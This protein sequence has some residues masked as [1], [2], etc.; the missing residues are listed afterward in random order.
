M[1]LAA[2][3]SPRWSPLAFVAAN[4]LA[5]V[6]APVDG[7]GA[8]IDG[9]ADPTG[10]DTRAVGAKSSPVSNFRRAT[11]ALNILYERR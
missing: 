5:L 4:V 3:P 6:I 10:S 1:R 8:C 2:Q 11:V 9:C 7:V